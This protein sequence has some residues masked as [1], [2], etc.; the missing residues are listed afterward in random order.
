MEL[1]KDILQEQLKELHKQA[2]DRYSEWRMSV[3]AMQYCEYLL[4]LL[5][6]KENEPAEGEQSPSKV[7]SENNVKEITPL[8]ADQ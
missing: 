7:E 8:I 5:K 4:G 6:Q 2:N 1:T 3:G